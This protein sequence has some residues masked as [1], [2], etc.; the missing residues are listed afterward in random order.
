MEYIE[1]RMSFIAPNLSALVGSTTAAK[2]I[3]VA[4]GLSALS[5]IPSCN[6]LVLGKTS[7]TN[8][9]L[10]AVGMK[11][12]TGFIYYSDLVS[13]VPEGDRKRVARIL[14]GKYFCF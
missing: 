12:H 10:S 9:G 14:A 13:S 2:L 5:K 7:K 3:S 4:G 6:L 8:T 1:S 11:K